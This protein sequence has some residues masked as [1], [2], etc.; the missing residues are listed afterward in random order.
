VN[1]LDQVAVCVV[2]AA[3]YALLGC[4]F[5]GILG[6]VGETLGQWV[7]KVS[8]DNRT[9]PV[10]VYLSLF[11][12]ALAFLVCQQYWGSTLIGDWPIERPRYKALY[13][14]NAFPG[15]DE[16]KN[17]RLKADV[18][19]DNTSEDRYYVSRMYF[20]NGGHVDMEPLESV[21]K[22]HVRYPY[23]DEDGRQWEVE[24]RTSGKAGGLRYEPLK[25]DCC[26][27]SWAAQGG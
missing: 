18:Y 27:A 23:T 25:A 10:R 7:R 15:G 19:V 9:F 14:I 4:V 24:V 21:T 20:P 5:V 11:A 26:S 3:T 13:W 2:A 8:D 6:V 1:T 16:V 17:Y 12:L 22:L